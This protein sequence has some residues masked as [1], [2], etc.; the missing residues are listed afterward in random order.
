MYRLIQAYEKTEP[1]P[2][3]IFKT[4]IF[5]KNIQLKYTINMVTIKFDNINESYQKVINIMY[6]LTYK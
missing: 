3:Y 2:L 1:K 5:N 4:C 6:K